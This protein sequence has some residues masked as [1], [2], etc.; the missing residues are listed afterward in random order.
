MKLQMDKRKL[1][2]KHIKIC[3]YAFVLFLISCA[4]YKLS[5]PLYRAYIIN[6][7]DGIEAYLEK[8][9][10]AYSTNY[11]LQNSDTVKTIYEIFDVFILRE[12]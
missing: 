5:N 12:T 6:S 8:W 7:E 10:K 4:L 1:T 3:I 2:K 9:N 11:T